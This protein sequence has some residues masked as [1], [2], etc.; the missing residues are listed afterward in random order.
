MPT[1]PV[2][3]SFRRHVREKVLRATRELAIEKGWTFRRTR[4]ATGR[5]VL[6]IGAGPSGLSAAYQLAMLGHD[7]EI[8]DASPEPGGMMRY[9]IPEYR[10]PRD[11]LD[12][13]VARI[14]ALGVRIVTDRGAKASSCSR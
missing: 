9:G 2:R 14:V 1:E 6:V 4:T 11:V 13:E 5:R 10:L 8:R 12:A 7:V 3:V